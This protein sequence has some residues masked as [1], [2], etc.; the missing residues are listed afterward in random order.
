MF[1]DN[2]KKGDKLPNTADYFNEL[3]KA[4][5]LA[6]EIKRSVYNDGASNNNTLTGQVV[7]QVENATGI[8]LPRLSILEIDNPVGR[9]GNLQEITDFVLNHG[10]I[11]R[12][13]VPN[14]EEGRTAV[15]TLT[16]LFP[17]EVNDAAIMGIITCP[18]EVLDVSHRFARPLVD[19][20]FQ[21]VSSESGNIRLVLQPSQPGMQMLDVM[22]GFGGGGTAAPTE[23]STTI[24]APVIIPAST[25]PVIIPASNGLTGNHSE[26]FELCNSNN[27]FTINATRMGMAKTG[28]EPLMV[29][30][31]INGNVVPKTIGTQQLYYRDLTWKQNDES[32]HE[33]TSDRIEQ[34]IMQTGDEQVPAYIGWASLAALYCYL[35]C[36][37][38]NIGNKLIKVDYSDSW[39]TTIDPAQAIRRN[40]L[41]IAPTQ[42][43]GYWTYPSINYNP[44]DNKTFQYTTTAL[45]VDNSPITIPIHYCIPILTEQ[46]SFQPFVGTVLPESCIATVEQGVIPTVDYNNE[47]TL[48]QFFNLQANQTRFVKCNWQ[49]DKPKVECDVRI[50]STCGDEPLFAIW[51]HDNVP[52]I[53][54]CE[55][56]PYGYCIP[57]K[58]IEYLARVTDADCSPMYSTYKYT[59]AFGGI[60]KQFMYQP[61]NVDWLPSLGSCTD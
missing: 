23:P 21:L 3:A 12:G 8:S 2:Y 18:V 28:H 19:N 41:I 10:I 54:L 44:A 15:I 27:A 60:G 59:V 16:N 33:F 57:I 52:Q 50:E 49:N 24:T 20:T 46:F 37:T 58:K 26:L 14:G 43:P 1:R 47:P 53:I 13:W 6:R 56:I 34:A 7:I 31:I 9:I 45:T 36:I 32:W 4:A 22:L 61:H 51:K 25:A 38:P 40:N 35:N 39:E 55:N 42:C 17:G 5:N 11:Y 29:Y 48:E 30:H